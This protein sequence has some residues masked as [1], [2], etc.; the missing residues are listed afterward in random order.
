MKSRLV[1]MAHLSQS[2]LPTIAIKRYA[3]KHGS[4]TNRAHR[5]SHACDAGRLFRH[6]SR[7]AGVGA[8][9][10]HENQAYCTLPNA[11]YTNKYNARQCVPES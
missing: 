5:Q 3:T 10:P 11:L 6:A 4:V 8:A 9:R 1:I 2:D 7:A